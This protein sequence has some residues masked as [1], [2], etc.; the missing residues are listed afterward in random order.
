MSEWS[1]KWFLVCTCCIHLA[2]AE[3]N[4]VKLEKYQKLLESKEKIN[5]CCGY[6]DV[7]L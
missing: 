1:P 3:F 4:I 5:L 2:P 6:L 7:E